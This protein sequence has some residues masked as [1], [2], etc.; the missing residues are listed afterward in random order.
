MRWIQRA[1]VSSHKGALHNQLGINPDKGI[2]TKVL[3]RIKRT[4]IGN[5]FRGKKVTTLLK[6]RV[7]FALN[8]RK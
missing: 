8:V 7:N 1:K 3:V 5:K 2:P 4:P 6:R